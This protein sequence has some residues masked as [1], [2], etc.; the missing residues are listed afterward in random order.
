L[1]KCHSRDDIYIR[2]LRRFLISYRRRSPATRDEL[3]NE[4]P[5][6]YYAYD[7][8]TSDDNERLTHY[9]QARLLARQTDNMIAAHTG[10]IPETIRYYEACF[11]NVRDRFDAKDWVVRHILEGLD[12]DAEAAND[13]FASLKLFGYFAGP[14]MLDAIISGFSHDRAPEDIKEAEEFYEDH[15]LSSVKR[16]SSIA[17]RGFQPDASNV[18]QL[19]NLCAK[20]IEMRRLGQDG[21]GTFNAMEQNIN[22]L[23]VE[24][25]PMVGARMGREFDNQDLIDLDDQ[26]ADLR[27]DELHL[28]ASGKATPLQLAAI[29]DE[30]VGRTI[31]ES[32][33]DDEKPK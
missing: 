17:I 18:M 14:V 5:G 13:S 26:E 25:Q 11:Y 20:V 6:L 22:A 29:R 33:N 8:F 3:V 24:I 10:G 19:F 31:P 1:G 15:F 21:E 7:L 28:V 27:D 23:L 16:H 12:E 9:I 32:R 30:V 4:Y 2:D